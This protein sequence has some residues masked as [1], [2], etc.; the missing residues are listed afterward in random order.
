MRSLIVATASLVAIAAP[1]SAANTPTPQPRLL[2][3]CVGEAVTT[4]NAA[5][6]WDALYMGNGE[7]KS[8][9]V[10]PGAN[11]AHGGRI[12]YLKH[13]EAHRLLGWSK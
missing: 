7:G 4:G 13:R 1:A 3:P 2:H 6:V 11:S 10:L 12:V 8:F 5:C 9:I